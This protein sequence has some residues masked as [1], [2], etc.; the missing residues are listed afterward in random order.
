MSK[1]FYIFI[2]YSLL[3]VNCYPQWQVISNQGNEAVS[4]P[5]SDT[6]Y[7]TANGITKKTIN[8]GYNWSTLSGGNLTG[9]FFIND[10]T[11]WVVG[12]PGYIGKTTN[13]TS[14][15][16]QP[17]AVTDRLNDV[18]FINEVP[19]TTGTGMNDMIPMTNSSWSPPK[20]R[21]FVSVYFLKIAAKITPVAIPIPKCIAIP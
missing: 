21:P 18:Y 11:G 8:G 5:S 13:G 1:L 3:F 4:F 15:T 2:I 7:S 19:P 12:Y 17:T 6:G 10:M 20:A 14:F 9:I 16:P